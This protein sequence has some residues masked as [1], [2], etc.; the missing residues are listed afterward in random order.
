MSNSNVDEIVLKNFFQKDF[1]LFIDLISKYYP[2]NLQLL[3]KYEDKLDWKKLSTNENVEWSISLIEKFADKLS[4]GDTY[5]SYSTEPIEGLLT[6]S[7][8]P[9]N[10]ELIRKFQD[11]FDIMYWKHISQ[12]ENIKWSISSLNEFKHKLDWD[13][14]MVTVN[15]HLIISYI[16]N[17]F[18]LSTLKEELKKNDIYNSFKKNFIWTYDLIETYNDRWFCAHFYKIDNDVRTLE[19]IDKYPRIWDWDNLSL[20]PWSFEQIKKYEHKWN[21]VRLSYNE[22]LPWSESF[23]DSF[24]DYWDYN[25]LAVNKS[26]PWTLDLIDKYN[27]DWVSLQENTNILWTKELLERFEKNIDSND[28]PFWGNGISWTKLS[29]RYSINDCKVDWSI[30][31]IRRFRKKWDWKFL[32]TNRLLP[33]SVELIDE[34]YF[35]WSH[36]DL[37]HSFVW[38][39]EI[40][41][42]FPHICDWNNLSRV[43]N[44]EWSH[45]LI[46]KFEDKWEWG[47]LSMKDILNWNEELIEQF[48]DRWNWNHLSGN[49]NLNWTEELI[50]KFKDRWNWDHLSGN[51]N[52]NW[53][54]ELI[55]KYED[56]WNWSYL[57]GNKSLNWTEELIE[58]YQDKWNWRQLYSNPALPWS[59]ELL[60]KYENKWIKEDK[61][62]GAYKITFTLD[63][64]DQ[65]NEN[66]TPSLQLWQCLEEKMSDDIVDYV[67][68]I[69]KLLNE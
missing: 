3:E 20:L 62:Y 27:L 51:K 52:L 15:P 19:L 11:R 38:N 33:W 34:F 6:N 47:F 42:T 18:N 48:K 29:G 28:G 64:L 63:F 46:Q 10:A 54:A 24:K 7:S 59:I 14:I 44:I 45:T 17:S 16:D 23:I 35:E 40:I 8:M 43:D 5:Y 61:F 36:S 65:S 12:N 4:W 32:S 26:I 22:Q 2:F 50:E 13:L 69:K 30:D 37:L 68:K 56:K 67:F 53:N 49:E 25:Y 55:E 58:K 31:L 1:D 39:E 57:S 9:W 60:N 66:F 41:K 21:W